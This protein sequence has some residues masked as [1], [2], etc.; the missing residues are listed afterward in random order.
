MNGDIIERLS[1]FS[2][3]IAAIIGLVRLKKIDKAFIPFIML[4]WLALLNEIVTPFISKQTGSNAVNTNVY[5]L[6]EAI[7]IT[8]FFK[9]L[10][11]FQKTQ[12][13]FAIVL[14]LFIGVW[15]IENFFISKITQFG[16]YFIIVYSFGVALMSISMVN[17]LIL[18]E[19]KSLLY[20]SVFLICVGFIIF[21]TYAALVEIFW[22]YGFK[23]NSNFS[24]YVYRILTYIN[25]FINLIYALALIWIPVKRNYILL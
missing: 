5:C 25:L 6:L 23:P 13:W 11:L 9:K 3:A 14:I 18:Q 20:N 19:K 22:V 10:G 16:S 12:K 8:I 21:Y 1:S 4:M 17:R 2:V 7:L 15:I 24:A